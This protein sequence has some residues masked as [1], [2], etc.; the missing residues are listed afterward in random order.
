MI[1]DIQDQFYQDFNYFRDESED[2]LRYLGYLKSLVP[3]YKREIYYNLLDLSYD[4]TC[5][6]LEKIDIDLETMK[7]QNH[8]HINY[9]IRY[10][11]SNFLSFDQIL[12]DKSLLNFL[13]PS[14]PPSYAYDQSSYKEE[15]TDY[16]P[17]VLSEIDY[18]DLRS[19][20]TI[21]FKDFLICEFYDDFHKIRSNYLEKNTFNLDVSAF[22]FTPILLTEKIKINV[23][24]TYFYDLIQNQQISTSK[25]NLKRILLFFF[26]DSN[27]KELSKN[28]IDDIFN[29]SK[30][31]SRSKNN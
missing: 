1:T 8:I 2:I 23:I 20:F 14:I 7:S 12:S 28:T 9:L 16:F 27:G 21:Y 6:Y 13:D 18:F 4:D 17:F 26:R 15:L 10:S 24:P 25:E 5:K 29:N 3:R 22:K 19:N 30:Y 31:A 11:D